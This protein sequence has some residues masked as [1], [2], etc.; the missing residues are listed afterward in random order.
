LRRR[1]AIENFPKI[2]AQGFEIGVIKGRPV[3]HPAD[4]IPNEII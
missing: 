4:R 3:R 1:E 2:G